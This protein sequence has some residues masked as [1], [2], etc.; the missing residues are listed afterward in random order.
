MR[1][2]NRIYFCCFPNP[3]WNAHCFPPA[4]EACGRWWSPALTLRETGVYPLRR[5]WNYKTC[6][7]KLWLSSMNKQ[8]GCDIPT[9]NIRY[10]NDKDW[11]AA[12]VT[13][14]SQKT[15]NNPPN[16][17]SNSSHLLPAIRLIS[18]PNEEAGVKPMFLITQITT[19]LW[20]I[21]WK[22]STKTKRMKAKKRY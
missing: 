22:S 13:L 16:P 1:D 2:Q 18:Q 15:D 6:D 8:E 12:A 10:K 5:R 19:L 20:F 17:N 11:E 14:R 3:A 21:V 9:M 7:I 4:W